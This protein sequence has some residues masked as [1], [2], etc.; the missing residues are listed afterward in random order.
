MSS[1]IDVL[2]VPLVEEVNINNR[3]TGFVAM[4]WKHGV[5]Q[6]N[7]Q[8]T[9]HLPYLNKMSIENL[10]LTESRYGVMETTA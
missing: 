8:R 9:T 1:W 7:R 4:K 10:F 5:A 3:L 2:D 6:N